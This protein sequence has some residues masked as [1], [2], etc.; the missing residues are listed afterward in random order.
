MSTTS[1]I[2]RLDR[3][4]APK[5]FKRR[6]ATWNREH[7]LLVDVVDIQ[8]S[9]SGDA[10]TL[11]AGVLSRPIYSTCWGTEADGFIKEPFCTVRARIGQ[12]LDNRDR[13][14]PAAEV[15]TEDKLAECVRSHILPF[16]DRMQ[17]FEGM[18]DWLASTGTPSAKSPL[19]SIC[20]AVL[21]SQ[22]GDRDA[23]CKT[24]SM[25]ETKALGAW[26]AR[27]REVAARVGC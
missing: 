16:I 20:F 21:Q 6:K 22:M 18:R 27:A 13:W 7:G 10:V 4:L 25:I 14:W 2:A 19:P 8:T 15:R 26:K 3:E 17:S 1:I 23:A 11:N 12:L 9:K 24:L 5:G